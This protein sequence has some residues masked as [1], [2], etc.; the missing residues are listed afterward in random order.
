MWKF[1]PFLSGM[2]M[3]VPVASAQSLPQAAAPHPGDAGVAVPATVYRSPLSGYRRFA[4]TA[5][6]PWRD[7]NDTTARIGGWK[8]YA[9]EIA[10]EG[11]DSLPP[12]AP[13]AERAPG[14]AAHRHQ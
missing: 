13:G 14:T 8:A 10:G 2:A 1:V 12:A 11:M 6:A 7:T 4:E 5:V 3:A 9:R